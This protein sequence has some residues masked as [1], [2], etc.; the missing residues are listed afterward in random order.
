[1]NFDDAKQYLESKASLQAA[2]DAFFNA[3]GNVPENDVIQIPDEPV[4]DVLDPSH[5]DYVRPPI[6]P[7]RDILVLPEE[8]NFRR[9]Y[10]TRQALC[11]MRNFAREAELQEQMMFGGAG[12]GEP[13][14]SSGRPKRSRLEDV[15]RPPTDISFAG[16][17]QMVKDFSKNEN[18]WL[19]INLQDNTEFSC[20]VLNRDVWSNKELKSIIKKYFV[21]YQV[22]GILFFSV[23]IST[24]PYFFFVFSDIR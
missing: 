9:R 15:F 11:P 17:F 16:T 10:N 20:Q 2:I 5:P 14:S 4:V 3:T 21:F 6:A 18:K 22:I 24:T 1:M 8:D 12:N 7:K 19:I 23:R 13:S